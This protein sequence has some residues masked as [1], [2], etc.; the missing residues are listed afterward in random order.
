MNELLICFIC[1]KF[2]YG[3]NSTSPD[4]VT[5]FTGVDDVTKYGIID[6]YNGRSHMTGWL[7]ERCN[8]LNGSD[9]SI[10]PPHIEKDDTIYIYD[11]DLCRLMPLVF[12][13]EV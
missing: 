6:K 3:K 7:E 11:K 12:E 9:G 8:R 1:F 5:M 4:R 2:S 10:F 13:K